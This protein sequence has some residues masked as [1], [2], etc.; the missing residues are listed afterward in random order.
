MEVEMIN[1]RVA[2]IG[3]LL[4]LSAG[5][6]TKPV[7]V[8][9]NMFLLRDEAIAVRSLAAEGKP[10]RNV[11]I[12]L[13]RLQRKIDDFDDVYLLE[14]AKD[15]VRPVE[16]HRRADNVV[17]DLV[18]GRTYVIVPQPQGRFRDLYE[19]L[20]RVHVFRA[21]LAHI[22]PG[23]VDD[24]C[25]FILCTPDLVPATDLYGHYPEMEP[26]RDD[27]DFGDRMVGGWGPSGPGN[28]CAKC[29]HFRDPLVIVPVPGCWRPLPPT[30]AISVTVVDIIPDDHNDET[31]QDSEPFLAVHPT[32]SETMTA[33]A[34]TPRDP[35]A[36]VG[37]CP[38]FVSSDSGHNWE[39]RHIVPSTP[40]TG[41]ITHAFD[42]DTGQ[43][44]T[45][46]LRR[47]GYLLMS[48]LLANN[49]VNTMTVLDERSRVDQPWVQVASTG[50]ADFI[51][52]GNNDLGVAGDQTATVDVSSD[53]G[54]TFNSIRIETRNTAG[55]NGPSI[56][57]AVADDG[58]V[59]AAYFGWRNFVGGG[60]SGTATSDIV[61]VRD[62]NR[63]TGPNPFQDLTDPS[64]GLAGR[65]VVT[66][67]TI[68][69]SN[70][71]TLGQER[72]GSTLS[73]AVH[74]QNSAIVYV[75]WGDREGT[76]DIYTL[77][78]RRSLDRG[79]TWSG[80]LRTIQD[81]T[82]V[83]L[84]VADNGTVGLL[85]Q[86][87]VEPATGQRRWV[88]H[89]EQITSSSPTPRDVILADVPA[90]APAPQF[91]PYIGDYAYLLAVGDEFRGIF[92]A[93]NTPDLNNFPNGVEYQRR[94][95]FSSHRLLDDDGNQ[96]AVSID[97]FYFSVSVAEN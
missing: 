21:P 17:G 80:D 62:D 93:N 82:C 11:A 56:R 41:D 76:G 83:A 3:V 23:L 48:E 27:L 36:P 38:I 2:L 90:D 25:K 88:T 42:D 92:S 60:V 44:Y 55:Q 32:D 18:G 61:V 19:V 77:H 84:A 37:T 1:W 54:A 9:S 24:I 94:A 52:V 69:W 78:V 47:P 43:L 75:A 6:R 67:V 95:D 97:P 45:G 85:Y 73:I 74:P 86:Q 34:F 12:S 57:T 8:P 10:Q 63:A 59:Y 20:C 81:A 70:Q 89:V 33:S 30:D 71:P 5:C 91:L 39:L 46:I 35:T 49:L 96:V 50:G 65:L 22:R 7:R 4:L 87:V 29:L 66:G 79:V 64:D 13:R 58:T 51:Y 68:P 72:I 28:I 14:Y 16:H 53:G 26:L 40:M 15:R 31:N